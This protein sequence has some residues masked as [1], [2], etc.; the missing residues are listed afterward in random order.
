MESFAKMFMSD[1]KVSL[2]PRN[3]NYAMD[4][5]K[6]LGEYKAICKTHLARESGPWDGL[7]DENTRGSKIS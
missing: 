3:P 5:L 7:F 6:Y 2:R 4:Y 1:L